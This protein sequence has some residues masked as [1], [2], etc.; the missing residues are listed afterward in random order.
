MSSGE[1]PIGATKGKQTNTM[2]L[3]QTPP[4]LRHLFFPLPQPAAVDHCLTPKRPLN[5]GLVHHQRF[6][7]KC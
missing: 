4:P 1:R 6:A 5:A 3:C 2:A 7:G